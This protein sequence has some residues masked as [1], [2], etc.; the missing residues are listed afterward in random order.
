[1]TDED[2]VEVIKYTLD[3][4]TQHE[5]GFVAHALHYSLV[6]DLHYPEDGFLGHSHNLA[7][8]TKDGRL[9]PGHEIFNQY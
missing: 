7:F 8:T 6:A 4:L 5:L 3:V 2:R 9:R 1:M